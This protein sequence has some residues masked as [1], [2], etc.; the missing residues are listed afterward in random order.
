MMIVYYK[1]YSARTL[2]LSRLH[3]LLLRTMCCVMRVY[4]VNVNV[5][6]PL[7]IICIFVCHAAFLPNTGI[8]YTGEQ[9]QHQNG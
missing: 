7:Y 6:Y 9:R 1:H 8:H 3:R 5:F 4:I 2:M